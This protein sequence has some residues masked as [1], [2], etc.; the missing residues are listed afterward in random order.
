MTGKTRRS[1]T[2]LCR[3][4]WAGLCIAAT[5]AALASCAPRSEEW[6]TAETKKE[7]RVD[8]AEF[9][10]SV[11]F[12]GSSPI[13]TETELNRLNG[14]L[15]R[16]GR[17]HG[18]QAWVGGG[19]S[20]VDVR[21]QAAIMSHLRKQGLP[22]RLLGRAGGAAPQPGT[23]RVTVVRHIVTLPNCGDWSLESHTN[24][25]NEPSS[26][27]GCATTANLGMMVANPR[28]LVRPTE[29][30][31]GDGQALSKGIENYH[32]DRVVV[33]KKIREFSLKSESNKSSTSEGGDK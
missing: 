33:S 29:V 31:P 5:L 4:P 17:G 30:G 19:T 32:D 23:V 18:V 12:Q 14:F 3:I 7:L 21:R 9:H 8:R 13:P 15:D 20:L 26:N 6:S 28:V 16:Q 1:F 27:F 2:R 24:H 22:A 11:R 25:S 10:H